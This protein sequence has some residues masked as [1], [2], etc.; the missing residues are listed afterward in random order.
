GHGRHVADDFADDFAA[1]DC[2]DADGGQPAGASAGPAGRR[3]SGYL[4]SPQ[5]ADLLAGLDA[6][7]GW[8]SCDTHV[9]WLCFAVGAARF[10]FSAEHGSAM[11]NPAWQA[12][13]PE[14][15]PRELIP[16]TVSLN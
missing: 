8:N 10:Y 6:W 5:T 13:V 1:S 7:L 14:L 3:Y 2:F 15:V 12:I 4:R 9:R 16:D 11:N